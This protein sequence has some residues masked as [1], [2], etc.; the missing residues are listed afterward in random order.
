[1]KKNTIIIRGARVNNL[2]NIDIDI[3]HNQL[4]VITGLSGSGKSSLAFD[5]IYAEGQRRYVESLS[6]YAR[7]FLEQMN[8]PD[9]DQIEGLSPAIAIDQK[10]GSH[11]PR[12]TVGTSTEIYDYLRLLFAKIGKP[13]CHKC[14]ELLQKQSI[15]QI[16]E[17]ILAM[18][19]N[20]EIL[21]LAPVIKKQKGEHK[22]IFTEIL[23]AGYLGAEIDGDLYTL[24]E[25]RDLEVDKK[26]KHDIDIIINRVAVQETQTFSELLR[27]IIKVAADLGNGIVKILVSETGQEIVF[28]D[29]YQ[30]PNCHVILGD[31]EPKTFS[32]NS[33]Q[34]ACQKCTGLGT[35]L[36]ID[37]KLIITNPKLTIAQGAI[38]PW[39]RLA[40]GAQNGQMKILELVAQQHNFSLDIP[41]GK[42]TEKQKEIILF[43]TGDEIYRVNNTESTF[44][45]VIPNLEK[46]YN[47]TDSDYL[48]TEIE[49]YM[50]VQ[51]CPKCKGKRL[52]EES[53]AV[54]IDNVSIAD[55]VSMD[56]LELR[57]LISQL[58][59]KFTP[60]EKK[61]ADQI[62][63]EIKRRLEHVLEIG[64]GYLTLNRT[65]ASL[66][67]GESQRIRLATQIGS[68]LTGVVYILDEPSIGL[69]QRDVGKLIDTLK[70]LRDLG[71]TV[72]VV[73]HDQTIMNSADSVIDVGPGAGRFGGLIVAQGTPSEIKKNPKSLTGKYL[74]GKTKIDR[75]SEYR[76][77]NKTFLT[78][79][80]AQEHNL[81]NVTVKIPLGTLTCITG[82]SGSGKSTLMK[83]ILSKALSHH[84]YKAKDLPGKHK[85]IHGIENIDKVITIDQSP[86]G[87][88]PRSNPATYT[89]VF[90]YIRDLFTQVPEAKIRGYDAGKFSFNVKGGRCEDC[91][92]EGYVRIEMK[93][94]PDVYV[95]CDLCHGKRYTK[96]ALEIH[97]RGKN[98]ADI[99]EMSVSES[100]QFFHDTPIIFEKLNILDDV[101][102]GYVKLGQS[103][104]T[105]SGGEAQRVKLATELSRRSTGKT[106]YILDEPTTGLH[107]DDIKK[108][109]SVLN[110]LV[111]KGNSVL[112][113]EHNLD[114]VQSSDWVI[115]MGPEGGREGGYIVAEGTPRD[116]GKIKKSYTGQ[117]LKDMLK[118]STP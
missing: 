72:I 67:G 55:Y 105:L 85:E 66:S 39:S 18:K 103:A 106:L 99:L 83:D 46:K 84:F 52:R 92:G 16:I 13:H 117:F 59:E 93:F 1:M 24:S 26:E 87:K 89:G 31:I 62:F 57:A 109:L 35:K 23:K 91:A 95:A 7:Q 29:S 41:V 77:G 94:L 50:R 6:S 76:K 102:L 38:K 111:D 70:H 104:T 81:K 21:F 9:V 75:K 118:E 60:R 110:R 82:V 88:T 73:E 43:G 20:T 86:I 98:I 107:F 100:K 48:Q 49:A 69:H 53:L 54:T 114:V 42:L 79:V 2:K 58:P 30:C 112:V 90:T 36:E 5:T 51:I 63:R 28:S 74:S 8:K 101:G 64:L 97:Y 27:E 32:F 10:S 34:G 108:L 19:P 4:I 3:P 96:K 44:E 15:E 37:P 22:K 116:I 11:N 14:G 80:D 33:P 65:I 68:Y 115:D 78:I 45:G 71:N 12:S 25:L 56:M 47:E 17:R 40:G 61:I 113:I